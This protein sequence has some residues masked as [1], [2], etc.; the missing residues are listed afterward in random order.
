M[1]CGDVLKRVIGA[2]FWRRYDRKL[3][4]Y[5][6]PWSQYGVA[7]SGEV[8]RSWRLQQR[9]VSTKGGSILSYDGVNVFNS[10]HRHIF[11]PALAEIVPSEVPYASNLYAREPP[12]LLL[13][14]LD[15]GV[16]K[17]V[18]SARGVQQG[19]NL[20]PLCYS[21][22]S[23]KIQ[24]RAD[25]LVPGAKVV[26]FISRYYFDETLRRL[27]EE[28]CRGSEQSRVGSS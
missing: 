17:G 25:P 20:G 10:I 1:A 9:W 14:V 28:K 13:F 15:G 8:E 19:C 16:L 18:E 7:V 11:L 6:Q 26:L 21:A 27:I 5:F 4:D 23:C 2:V 12:K 24:L 22:G 3:A